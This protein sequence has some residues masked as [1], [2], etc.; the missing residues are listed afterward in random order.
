MNT[1]GGTIETAMRRPTRH[2]RALSTAA[3]HRQWKGSIPTQGRSRYRRGAAADM[4][5]H[6]A[7]HTRREYHN[8]HPRVGR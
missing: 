8:A 2:T 4:R 6:T 7:A 1:R 3:D 5:R